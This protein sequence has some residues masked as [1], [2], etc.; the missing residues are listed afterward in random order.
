MYLDDRLV[1]TVKLKFTPG[2]GCNLAKRSNLF[3]K[4]PIPME[5][6]T[7][8]SGLPGK[9]IHVALA[10]W[11]LAGMRPLDKLKVTRQALNLLHVSD[12][13]YRD[14]LPRLEQAGLIKVWRAP[15]QRA[16]VEIVHNITQ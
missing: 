16:Q 14:A 6:V 2:Q 10:I 12:D 13:A 9:A 7:K 5:W 8:A 15:G 4:G 11:W 1:P 3:I